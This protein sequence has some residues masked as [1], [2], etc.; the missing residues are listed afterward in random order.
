[1][2][3]TKIV[4]IVKS[5]VKTLP[6]LAL[7]NPEAFKIV[8]IDA[9]NIGYGGILMQKDGNQERLV[10]FTSG[11]WNKAQLN[12]STIKKIKIKHCFMHFKILR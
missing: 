4:K 12:Y 7:V 8:E 2:K 11:T 6:C 3:N 5:R 10:N 9:S 1:M